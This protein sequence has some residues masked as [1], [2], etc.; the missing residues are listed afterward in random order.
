MWPDAAVIAYDAGMSIL[1][2][3]ALTAVAVAA[4]VPALAQV[5]DAAL[6]SLDRKVMAELTG[7]RETPQMALPLSAR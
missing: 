5:D 4:A 3:L 1:S 2:R 6:T 7:V